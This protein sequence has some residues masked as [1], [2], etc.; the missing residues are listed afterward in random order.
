MNLHLTYITSLFIV[1][2]TDE[3]AP[4]SGSCACLFASSFFL[5]VFFVIQYFNSK[6]LNDVWL[7]CTLVVTLHMTQTH[8]YLEYVSGG[9]WTLISSVPEF[10]MNIVQHSLNIRLWADTGL[11]LVILAGISAM[12]CMITVWCR[13]SS[14]NS[15][16]RYGTP[17]SRYFCVHP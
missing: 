15:G 4:C 5:L 6:H 13:Q 3:R 14:T 11:V 1:S 9:V 16:S 7:G 2:L 10:S 8:P 12:R 17:R